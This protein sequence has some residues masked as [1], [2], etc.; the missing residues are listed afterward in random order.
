MKLE[1][2]S[3]LENVKKSGNNHQYMCRCP[4]HN[5]KD[6]SLAVKFTDDGR[7]LLHCFAG[8]CGVDDICN[9]LGISIDYL[10]PNEKIDILKPTGKIYNPYAILKSLKNEVLLVAIA[11]AEISKNKEI[12]KGDMERL[13]VAVNKIRSAYEYARK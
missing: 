13:W 8:T 9:S 7:I 4:A 12:N 10:L 2:L 11:G 3:M 1:F 5:D 6:N